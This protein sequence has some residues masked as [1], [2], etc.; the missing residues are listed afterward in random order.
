MSQ[1]GSTKDARK[2]SMGSVAA[3]RQVLKPSTRQEAEQEPE[4]LGGL[5]ISVGAGKRFSRARLAPVAPQDEAG[6]A[7]VP[8]W[9]GSGDPAT[10]RHMRVL[11]AFDAA[12]VPSQA[13]PFSGSIN[14]DLPSVPQT[15]DSPPSLASRWSPSSAEETSPCPPSQPS[16]R[17]SLINPASKRFSFHY[18]TAAPSP[19]L[20]GTKPKINIRKQGITVVGAQ[21]I[22]ADRYAAL[23]QAETRA[24]VAQRNIGG[25]VEGSSRRWSSATFTD[26]GIGETSTPVYASNQQKSLQRPPNNRSAS[27]KEFST[28]SAAPLKSKLRD[29]QLA[30]IRN[31]NGRA[32]STSSAIRLPV[33]HPANHHARFQSMTGPAIEEA[34][35]RQP[36]PNPRNPSNSLQPS[37]SKLAEGNSPASSNPIHQLPTRKLSA[38]RL[39]IAEPRVSAEQRRGSQASRT[40]DETV[41]EVPETAVGS[42][43]SSPVPFIPS[44]SAT[45]GVIPSS[46]GTRRL[47]RLPPLD[48]NN[49]GSES[50]RASNSS[51]ASLDTDEFVLRSDGVLADPKKPVKIEENASAFSVVQVNFVPTEST[52]YPYRAEKLSTPQ[53]PPSAV[54]TLE[55]LLDSDASETS[56]PPKSFSSSDSLQPVSCSPPVTLPSDPNATFQA[57]ASPYSEVRMSLPPESSVASTL[58]YIPPPPPNFGNFS[59][60]V[61]AAA[62]SPR[63]QSLVSPMTSQG[64]FPNLDDDSKFLSPSPIIFTPSTANFGAF[65]DPLVIST[66]QSGFADTLRTFHFNVPESPFNPTAS[67]SPLMSHVHVLSSH[68]GSTDSHLDGK[69]EASNRPHFEPIAWKQSFPVGAP[70][71]GSSPVESGR[72]TFPRRKTLPCEPDKEGDDNSTRP[73]MLGRRGTFDVSMLPDLDA[74]RV[75]PIGPEASVRESKIGDAGKRGFNRGEIR[76]WML[77]SRRESAAGRA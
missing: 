45:T 77:S 51:F 7:L 74:Y 38:F 15:P 32:L 10:E 57:P 54:F 67:F 13:S 17:N 24:A 59:F 3:G 49:S 42:R 39:S 35:L 36:S 20:S 44:A 60:D 53:T 16:F 29:T 18:N 64:A 34:P 56:L 68:A 63:R 43:R 31:Q 30:E 1:Q 66:P 48:L 58:A 12:R 9:R 72:P 27:A 23:K 52:Y 73:R 61:N 70:S 40:S 75:G 8:D 50:S 71:P 6:P 2:M 55:D 69:Y 5:R 47:P 26:A 65:P 4:E 37:S 46:R 14:H 76:N 62:P 11:A 33:G 41:F 19:P 22:G 21:R 28:L 25:D